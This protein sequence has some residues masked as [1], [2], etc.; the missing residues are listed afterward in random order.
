MPRMLL[1]FAAIGGLTALT[2]FGVAAAPSTAGV[3]AAGVHAVPSQSLVTHAGYDWHPHHRNHRRW[4]H[5]RWHYW[6]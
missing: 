5:G 2:A 1:A 6:D 4:D 3:S